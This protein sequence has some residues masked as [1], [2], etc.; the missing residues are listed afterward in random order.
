MIDAA[1][2]LPLVLGLFGACIGSFL[3]VVIYRLPREELSIAKP[4]RSFC[5]RCK[6]QIS[7]SENI[8][9]LAWV[10]LG[11]RCRGC[12]GEIGLRYPLVEAGTAWLF[13]FWGHL[14]WSR[15]VA[16]GEDCALLVI[17]LLLIAIC[18]VVTFIDIDW[19]IIPDEITITGMVLAPL[20]A[21][22]VPRLHQA[23]WLFGK[24]GDAGVERHL[25]AAGSSL[26]G[27]LV[28]GGSL[29]L[30]GIGGRALFKPKE[31]G[32]ATDAM[33]FGDVKFMAAVGAL[34]GMESVLLI[35]FVGCVTGSLGG[36]GNWLIG[37]PSVMQDI[38]RHAARHGYRTRYI[39]GAAMRIGWRRRRFI[40]FG[41]FLSVGVLVVFFWRAELVQFL[42]HDW[43]ML[44]GSLFLGQRAG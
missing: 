21:I 1:I 29:W 5:P 26:A 20:L 32:E 16:G 19:R 24:L 15:G 2:L 25:A 8:P 41:P 18:I 22:G 27:L 39:V 35:F 10:F 3:N 28:G 43:P 11:G 34:L 31:A 14:A 30:V 40:P 9:V 12:K 7:W 13:G 6:R 23:S 4:A 44:V 36:V 33:G 37:L 38:A 42:L 17:G